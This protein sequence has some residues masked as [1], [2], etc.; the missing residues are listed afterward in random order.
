M[1]P[2][3]S[4][5][6]MAG[7]C[8]AR[9]TRRSVS[10]VPG[11][12]P[13]TDGSTRRTQERICRWVTS[14]PIDPPTS[15]SASGP[16]RRAPTKPARRDGHAGRRGRLRRQLVPGAQGPAA[17]RGVGTPRL[18]GGFQ[19]RRRLGACAWASS[20]G[21]ATA[22]VS[23]P[24]SAPW[25]A[26]ASGST[27]TPSWG[28]VTAGKAS[29]RTTRI[30]LGI[31]QVTGILH[32]G[33][34]ILGSSGMNPFRVDG[35]SG[36]GARRP[37]S[38]GA[39]RLI[40]IGGEGTLGAAAGF[41]ERGVP[42]V[43]VPK[44]IDNDLAG[45]DI[46]VGFHTAVQ[47][48]TDAIDRLHSTAESHDRVMLVE[49]M[50]RHAGWIAIYAGHRRRRRRHPDPRASVRHRGRVPAAPPPAHATELVLDRRGGRGGDPAGGHPRRFPSPSWTRTG[51]RGWAV[52]RITSRRRSRSGRDSRP[53]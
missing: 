45:T 12:G 39:R 46:T 20:R 50:G 33:G 9:V 27:A 2:I 40:A 34:T 5:R 53:G 35:G 11:V 21:A 17:D 26:R 47:V 4:A 14:G 10:S 25:S 32:R 8:R 29:W 3:L 42:V 44:T 28:S 41:A 51:S 18:P 37:S 43:G 31:P 15:S 48:A 13:M 24:S 23:T 1:R 30:G 38:A 16:R 19:G 36:G 22:P 49:V 52:S 6:S 7:P